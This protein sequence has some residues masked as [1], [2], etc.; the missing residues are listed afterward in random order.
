[1]MT[2]LTIALGAFV[3]VTASSIPTGSART[4]PARA[5]PAAPP[6]PRSVIPD[7]DRAR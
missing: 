7:E 4:A 1:M 5:T 2:N 3:L 6:P